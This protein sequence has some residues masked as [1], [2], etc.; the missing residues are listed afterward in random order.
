ME[1]Y[2]VDN[3]LFYD[4]VLDGNIKISDPKLCNF[5]L[6]YTGKYGAEGNK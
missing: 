4:G 6:A 5:K 2:N 3:H 1:K